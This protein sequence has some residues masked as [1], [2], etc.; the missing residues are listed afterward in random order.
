MS[1]TIISVSPFTSPDRVYT[2]QDTEHTSKNMKHSSQ[3][4]LNTHHNILNIHHINFGYIS[5]DFLI[6][7]NVL[8]AINES[9]NYFQK[10]IANKLCTF[11]L[12]IFPP[13]G[14]CMKNTI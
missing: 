11:I 6:K 9:I 2:S 7:P 1:Q 8:H 12:F 3:D 4:L 13:L 5:H 10:Q 14:D